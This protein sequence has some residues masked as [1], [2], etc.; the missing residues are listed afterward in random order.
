MFLCSALAWA[1]AL[2]RMSVAEGGVSGVEAGSASGETASMM[3]A[4]R[5]T[6]KWERERL[7]GSTNILHM[8]GMRCNDDRIHIA[9]C[10]IFAT[11]P[12]GQL[13]SNI[14]ETGHN[15]A[16]FQASRLS[17]DAMRRPGL[18]PVLLYLRTRTTTVSRWK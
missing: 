17:T 11:I 1:L 12:Q 10:Q 3:A 16:A 9:G 6:R 8:N 4:A 15:Y 13:I 7:A 5:L 18:F 2:L 14:Q